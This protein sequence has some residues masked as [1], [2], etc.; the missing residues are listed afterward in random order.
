[1]PPT[2]EKLQETWTSSSITTLFRLCSA[3]N[4]T[5]SLLLQSPIVGFSWSLTLRAPPQPSC[6][7]GYQGLLK[8][9]NETSKC[10]KCSKCIKCRKIKTD[11]NGPLMC[12]L[13]FDSSNCYSLWR[14]EPVKVTLS[15]PSHPDRAIDSSLSVTSTTSVLGCN[16]HLLVTYS[17]VSIGDALLSLEVAFTDSPTN[18]LH[19]LAHACPVQQ[20]PSSAKEPNVP[21]ARAGLSALEQSLKTGTSFDIVFQAYTRRI[22]PGK[23]TRPIPIYANTTVLQ[24][25]TLLPD[26]AAEEDLN[27]SPLFELPEGDTPPLTSPESYE[28]ESD[29]DLDD[30]EG[31]NLA[32]TEPAEELTSGGEAS[33]CHEQQSHT[34]AHDAQ[35]HEGLRVCSCM[36]CNDSHDDPKDTT[37][38]GSLLSFSTF[39]VGLQEHNRMSVLEEAKT[40]LNENMTS[41]SRVVLVK[42]VAWKTPSKLGCQRSIEALSKFTARHDAVREMEIALLVTHKNQP[43]VLRGLPAK[44]E[45]MAMG[46]LP[47]AGPV[48]TAL[49]IPANPQMPSPDGN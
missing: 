47:H 20:A 18:L 27:F 39:E 38:S 42:G 32:T 46:N 26:F 36:S 12:Q 43:D 37:D 9:G 40:V 34:P 35:P 14:G 7:L 19:V 15:F 10:S 13:F 30:D 5:S 24:A 16:L 45:A 41:S 28:Y 22:S 31:N 3:A 17:A 8:N 33:A 1:M 2:I 25:I 44:I 48:L 6:S 29:S 23:V 4:I 49:I 21:R 11:K